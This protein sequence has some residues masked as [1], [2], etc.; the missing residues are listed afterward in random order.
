MRA[1]RRLAALVLLTALA[2]M[3]A[4]R[5]QPSLEYAVKAAYLAKFAPFIDWPA[6]AFASP[7]APLN[8][9]I[10]GPDPFGGELEKAVA[11]QK[12]GDH[13]MAV[14]RMERF[15]P[16]AVCQILFTRDATLVDG[17]LEALQIR[18]VVTVT[19]SGLPVHGIISFA[20]IDNHVRFDIDD[21][22]AQRVGL[23]ISSKLLA[24]AHAV[25]HRGSP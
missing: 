16:D 14:R 1:L 6:G 17:A 3:A 7:I 4:A 20:V 13:L 25:R 2:G 5:A 22:A 21:A 23:T 19:D 24:L 11:G 10:L 8:I 12:D 9:C 15:E 18:P